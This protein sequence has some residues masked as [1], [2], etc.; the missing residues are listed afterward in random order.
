MCCNGFGNS[1]HLP[2]I[3]II[4]R[5][6][7]L[8]A[9]L[10]ALAWAL[11]A[12]ANPLQS[13]IDKG[14]KSGQSVIRIPAGRY[15][16]APTKGMHLNLV[17]LRNVTIDARGVEMIC[18]ETT[19]AIS[20]RN[21]E[22]LRIVGLTIDYD[23]LPFTQG[24]I[25]EIAEDRKSHV[26]EIMDGFPPAEEA[27]VFKHAV[28]TPEGELRFGNYY[29]FK[30]E[31][32]SPK[33]LRIHG[34][35]PRKD[36]GE[37]L[38]DIVVVGTQHLKGPYRPHAVVVQNSAGTI[39]E[40]VTLYSSPCFGFLEIASSR[41][42][43]R[44]CVID[45]REG[46]MRSLNADAFHSKFAEVGPQ[47][48]NCKAMWQGDDCVNI[49]GDYYL[50]ESGEGRKWRLLGPGRFHLSPGDPVELVS[51]DGL[52]LPDAV[53]ISAKPVGDVSEADKTYFSSLKLNAKVKA[54]LR[55]V[56]SIEL[57]REV[58]LPRGSVIASMKRKG[59]G[60]AVKNCTFGNNRSRGILIK[61]SE[62]EV[63]G[64]Y[65]INT[66]GEAIKITPE[67]HWLESGFSRNV[68][69]R[70]NEIINPL[71]A[72]VR[73]SGVGPF[74]GHQN[75]QVLENVIRTDV[76][77]AMQ[78]ESLRKGKVLDNE[79]LGTDGK[80]VANAIRTRHCE[81]VETGYSH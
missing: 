41:S 55:T 56:Y 58:E 33:L 32:L 4:K 51:P 57:D 78:I 76:L 27:Y 36:G 43:Y 7:H 30:L 74:A 66:H 31:V 37:Q 39:L 70:N 23:P 81:D 19:L 77:P 20:I 60:F 3:P 71:K 35:N 29:T 69:V 18:T 62:G 54:A 63:S 14:V 25:V 38:G 28:Y 65:L 50:V 75:I 42:V 64:N 11:P 59:N 67:Y 68:I 12:L 45:R 17:G 21:C 2:H 53:A 6:F 16:V 44:N 80:P 22:N 73:I 34:L 79:I 48:I 26:I 46:R 9:L 72:A 40:D 5:S 47:I 13:I 49:C 24:R 10:G 8:F 1:R 61:A 15:E 52:R